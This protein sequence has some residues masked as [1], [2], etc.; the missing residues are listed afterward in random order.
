[1]N[2]IFKL[3]ETL[4]KGVN[5]HQTSYMANDL[6]H[7]CDQF[8]IITRAFQATGSGDQINLWKINLVIFIEN[9]MGKERALQFAERYQERDLLCRLVLELG[10]GYYHVLHNCIKNWSPDFLLQSMNII[11]NLERM[12]A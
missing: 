4:S 9:S 12:T 6:Y 3:C 2:G 7:L 1:M 5:E 8:M 11:Y 10:E